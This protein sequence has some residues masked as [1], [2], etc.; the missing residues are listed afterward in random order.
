MRDECL[1]KKK[2]YNERHLEKVREYARTYERENP[3]DRKEY[4][5]E[6]SQREKDTWKNI[7]KE[8]RNV[9]YVKV[10]WR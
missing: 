2:R 7:I 10:K 4:M 3:R 8:K 9:N 5:K 1:E 6:Y